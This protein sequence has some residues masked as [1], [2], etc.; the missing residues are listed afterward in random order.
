MNASHG[1]LFKIGCRHVVCVRVRVGVGCGFIKLIQV[2]NSLGG[3]QCLMGHGTGI[4][5]LNLG[6]S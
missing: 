5:W 6:M 3:S 1:S 4:D 2:S